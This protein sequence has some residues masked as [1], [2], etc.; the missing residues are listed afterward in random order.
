MTV[1]K[2]LTGDTGADK[3]GFYSPNPDLYRIDT[4]TDF[5]V[6]DDT[7]TVSDAGFGSGLT[8]GAAITPD[9]FVLG[10]VARDASNRFIYNQNT[11]ALF[12]D[13]DGTGAIGQLQLATLSTGLAMTNANIFVT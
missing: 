12:F 13:K 8:A 6:A 4:I 3:F 5:V 11:G 1:A 10:A 7:I 9:Q 2:K